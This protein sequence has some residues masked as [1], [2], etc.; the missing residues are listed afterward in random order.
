MRMPRLTIGRA[1][2]S[3]LGGVLAADDVLVPTIPF[4]AAAPE[5][6]SPSE[7]AADGHRAPQLHRTADLVPGLREHPLLGVDR[8][9]R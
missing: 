2:L 5:K 6:P 8:V 9:F 4:P 7:S 1:E 3:V